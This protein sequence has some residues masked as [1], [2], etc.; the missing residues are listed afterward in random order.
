MPFANVLRILGTPLAVLLSLAISADSAQV[1]TIALREVVNRLCLATLAAS[2]FR[3]W[4]ARNL[5]P[6]FNQHLFSG[7][8]SPTLLTRRINVA[9]PYDPAVVPVAK[10]LCV[11]R[12]LAILYQALGRMLPARYVNVAMPP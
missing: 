4:P 12:L 2:T 8:L 5:G 10:S 11:R 3:L 1:T 7:R 6:G 9:V